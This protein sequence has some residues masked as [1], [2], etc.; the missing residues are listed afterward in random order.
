MNGKRIAAL[1]CVTLAFFFYLSS[2]FLY[3]ADLDQ[4]F[5]EEDVPVSTP[6]A[7]THDPLE[8]I[9]RAFFTFND[10]LY[11]WALKPVSTVYAAVLPSKLR[12][13]IRN[14]FDNLLAPVRIVNNFLQGKVD[15]SGKELVRFAINTTVGVGGLA[16][17]AKNDF[18]LAESDEDLGQTLGI[19]GAGEGVYICWP[20]IGPS[21]LRDTI[22]LVG[23][24]F[25][26]PIYYLTGGNIY[27]AAGVK[28]GERVNDVSLRLGDYERWKEAAIDPYV[29]MRQAYRQSRQ[30]EINDTDESIP[31][32]EQ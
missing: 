27:A 14:A 24:G 6:V 18:H 3:A 4:Y 11:F 7:D 1:V 2:S 9:N 23:D 10:K 19:Y 12:I 32:E 17:V 28:T 15:R 13:G 31:D 16:D 29:S 21:N 30:N 22:G 26:T 5:E 8:P 25:I 20:F